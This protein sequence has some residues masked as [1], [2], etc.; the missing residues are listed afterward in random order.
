M[1]YLY[2]VLPHMLDNFK[3]A[4]KHWPLRIKTYTDV[5][6][7]F[8]SVYDVCS[9]Y[10]YRISHTLTYVDAI[11]YSMTTLLNRLFFILLFKPYSSQ[12]FCASNGT[13]IIIATV[14]VV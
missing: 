13:K 4:Q 7:R 14:I 10:P 3:H 1:R 12:E 6:Q 11:G 2:A 5:C 8:M 9:T